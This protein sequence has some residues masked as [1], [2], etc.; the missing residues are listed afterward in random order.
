MEIFTK[1]H[2]LSVTGA[3]GLK[4]NPWVFLKLHNQTSGLEGAT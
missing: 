3:L 4:A 2:T 1:I